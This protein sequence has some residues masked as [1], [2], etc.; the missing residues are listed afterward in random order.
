MS[1]SNLKHKAAYWIKAL[2]LEPHPEGGY[3]KRILESDKTIEIQPDV[4]RKS[5]SSIYYLLENKDFSAFHKLKS[6][7]L[8][9]F[10]AGDPLVIYII[11]Q[12]GLL[13]EMVLGTNLDKN[14]KLQVLVKREQ[15]FAA[16]PL[17]DSDYSLVGCTVIPGFD[18]DDWELGKREELIKKYPQHKKLIESLTTSYF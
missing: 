18:F 1:S 6:D 10:Y 17:S 9:H 12:N 11:Q 4:Y 5:F 3:F 8:W 15:W 14:E 7:E 13:E 16:Q 2:E